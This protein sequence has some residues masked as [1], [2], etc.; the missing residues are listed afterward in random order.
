MSDNKL[1]RFNPENL[2]SYF[3]Q[4]NEEQQSRYLEK[5]ASDNAELMN[6]A[7]KKVAD[8]K[9]AENDMYTDLEFIGR[10]ETEN[11]VI[12]IE[13]TYESGSG[14]MKINI[15]GGDR[16]LIIPVFVILGIVIIAALVIVFWK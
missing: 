4:L 14:R 13:R 6:Y 8:S 7:S 11:K 16:R 5:L 10:L 15:K 2:P 1:S 9:T 12:N 3:S